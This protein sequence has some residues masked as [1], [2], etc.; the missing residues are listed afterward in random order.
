MKSK[1]QQKRV[2]VLM[3][4]YNG[5]KYLQK[6]IESIMSQ[7]GL[8]TVDLLIRDDGSAD[9]TKKIIEE[10]IKK[11][12]D[13][14]KFI[15]GNNLG[16]NGSFFELI[17]Q[18][19]GYDYYA[20]SDQDDVWLPDKLYVA[21]KFLERESENVPLLYAS[22]SYLVGDDLKPYGTT[23]CQKREFTIFN[24][25]VQNICPGHTQVFNNEL[26]A[27]LKQN[28]DVSKIYVYDSWVT[29]TAMLYGK[30]CFDN[31]SHTYYRQHTGNQL[32]YGNG[33]IGQLI[34]SIKHTGSGDGVKYKRQ[35][36]YFAEINKNALIEQGTFKEIK[37]FLAICNSRFSIRK[38]K[39]VLNCKFYRQRRI[40]TLALYVAILLGKY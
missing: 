40:E 38:I 8:D 21:C 16:Y 29:N 2:L 13:R 1:V 26:L 19:E 32:G 39:S 14:I 35:I 20:F 12:S 23:R 15:Y 17:R 3:S 36:A 5:E 11:Y 4:C 27:L 31:Q 24:T 22:T 37:K 18:S 7:R 25:L 30:V 33:K 6:Q 9:G 28:I 34:T 10:S